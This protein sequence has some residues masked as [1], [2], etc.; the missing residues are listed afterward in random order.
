[1]QLVQTHLRGEYGLTVSDIRPLTR[2]KHS[3]TR[4]R[5][6]LHCYIAQ[7]TGEAIDR[8]REDES[9]VERAT[10]SDRPMSVTGRKFAVSLGETGA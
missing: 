4:Y 1:M 9:W 8:L 10:L 7:L 2:L 5:I 6:D 3:V